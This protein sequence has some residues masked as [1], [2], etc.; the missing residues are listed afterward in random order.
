PDRDRFDRARLAS[1]SIR[2]ADGRLVPLASLAT[3]EARDGQS[4]LT[5]ENLRQ[6]ALLTARLE[7][8][9]LGS[10]VAELERRLAKVKLPV[11]YTFE[12]GG[13]Y[14]AQRQAF[15]ELLSVFAVAASLVLVLLV[16]QFR[17]FT[18]ALLILAAAPLSLAGAFALLWATG[19]ELN[20]ASAMG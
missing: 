7:G 4:V 9:D 15:G 12:V 1:T 16:I 11:G 8:R 19:T 5:R 13:Q 20:V 17:A 3:P 10:A 2:S 6:M 14:A 18:P